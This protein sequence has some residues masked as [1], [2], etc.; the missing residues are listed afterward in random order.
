MLVSRRAVLLKIVLAWLLSALI[1]SPI[2]ILGL[3][4]RTNVQPNEFTC[5]IQNR[6]FMILGKRT[7]AVHHARLCLPKCELRIALRSAAFVSRA[8]QHRT[9]H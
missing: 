1:T 4:D 5:A 2:T 9:C 8:S 6:W 3:I 7:G